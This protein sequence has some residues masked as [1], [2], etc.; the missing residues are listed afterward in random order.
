MLELQEGM[1][2]SEDINTLFAY[3]G[4]DYSQGWQ[5]YERK[6]EQRAHLSLQSWVKETTKR[7]KDLTIFEYYSD[8]FMLSHLFPSLP[9]R[10]VEDLEYY[11]A[12]GITAITNLVVPYPQADESYSWKWAQGYNS[13]VFSR[14]VWGDSY[15]AI[16][17]DY[18]NTY[19]K[20]ERTTLRKAMERTGEILQRISAYNVPLF[21]SRIVDVQA[22]RIEDPRPIV[23]I[24]KELII[25]LETTFPGIQSLPFTELSPV[26]RYLAHVYKVSAELAVKWELK[27]TAQRSLN[28]STY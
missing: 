26:E 27:I 28:S 16:T 22:A 5:D 8:H 15:E 2:T 9:G 23:N 6:E 18:W 11:R 17:K 19:A 20:E 4:R 7:N 10:I 3:W 12:L 14:A 21:P 13:Y 1:E 24:L 25:E